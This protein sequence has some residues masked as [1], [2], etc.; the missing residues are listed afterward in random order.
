MIPLNMGF[1]QVKWHYKVHKLCLI[2]ERREKMH[3]EAYADWA[4]DL[5]D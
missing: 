1:D 5:I 4:L 3:Q 2:G